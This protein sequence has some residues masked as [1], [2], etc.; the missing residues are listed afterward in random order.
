MHGSQYME[1]PKCPSTDEWIKKMRCVALL[2]CVVMKYV[3]GYYSATRRKEILPFATV[4][5]DLEGM[6]LNKINQ[7]KTKPVRYHFYV[8][9]KT[10]ELIETESRRVVTSG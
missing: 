6:K 8:E 10:T 7:R 1:Q 5:M 2:R 4:W 9:A 3:T